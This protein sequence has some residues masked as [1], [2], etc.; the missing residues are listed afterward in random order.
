MRVSARFG[1]W[2]P[3]RQCLAVLL[4]AAAVVCVPHDGAS[5]QRAHVG[6]VIHASLAGHRAYV[7]TAQNVVACLTLRTGEIGA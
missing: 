1:S 2:E 4:C 3:R 5:W 7:T 6:R